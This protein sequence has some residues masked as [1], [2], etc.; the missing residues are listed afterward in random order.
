[1]AFPARITQLIRAGGTRLN[2]ILG[3]SNRKIEFLKERLDTLKASFVSD[4]IT[5]KVFDATLTKLNE[6]FL[7]DRQKIL[8]DAIAANR[9][10]GTINRQLTEQETDGPDI[11]NT[12]E[13]FQRLRDVSVTQFRRIGREL[14]D[15]SD[16]INDSRDIPTQS[17]SIESKQ[18]RVTLGIRNVRNTFRTRLKNFGE[19]VFG[20]VDAHGLGNLDTETLQTSLDDIKAQVDKITE[21]AN[22]SL[23]AIVDVQ[24]EINAEIRQ[25]AVETGRNDLVNSLIIS[26]RNSQK[27]VENTKRYFGAFSGKIKEG[28][29]RAKEGSLGTPSS[30]DAPVVD[31]RILFPPVHVFPRNPQFDQWI[32]PQE[33]TEFYKQETDTIEDRVGKPLSTRMDSIEFDVG[34]GGKRNVIKLSSPVYIDYSQYNFKTNVWDE[35]PIRLIINTKE[36]VTEANDITNYFRKDVI[37]FPQDAQSINDDISFYFDGEKIITNFDFSNPEDRTKVEIRYKK[38]IDNVR[39]KAVLLTTSPG[40]VHKTPTVDQYTLVLG[41]QKVLN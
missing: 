8:N 12:R 25:L 14:R 19:R 22:R 40:L 6:Q 28:V 32:K 41:R 10:L 37:N 31:N 36:A 5:K 26:L 16:D 4:N 30:A 2:G 21:N 29:D 24:R 34:F 17:Q 1:M 35:R 3:Q 11:D 13:A 39:V 20:L 9:F 38:L 23:Q 33:V 15:L 18:D 27:F 7:I